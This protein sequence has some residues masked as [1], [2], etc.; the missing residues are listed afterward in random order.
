MFF[1]L[2][3]LWLRFLPLVGAPLLFACTTT[4]LSVPTSHPGNSLAPTAQIAFATLLP[5]AQRAT[6]AAGSLPADSAV[7]EQHHHGSDATTP[8]DSKTPA[9]TFTC[10]M[11][12]EIVRDQPGNCHICGMKLV[13]KKDG[14]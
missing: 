12:P 5:R 6:E 8:A 2:T 7:A 10:V 13:P 9:A 4:E 1:K 3:H 11:H 14:K